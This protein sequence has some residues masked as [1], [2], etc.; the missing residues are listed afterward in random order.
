MSLKCI[1]QDPAPL[2]LQVDHRRGQGLC[3][4][5]I[6]HSY[7]AKGQPSLSSKDTGIVQTE[8]KRHSKFFLGIKKS[9]VYKASR[10]V[11]GNQKTLNS[12]AKNDEF[13]QKGGIDLLSL[14]LSKI[15][16]FKKIFLTSE[17]SRFKIIQPSS[18]DISLKTK[19]PKTKNKNNQ[20][21]ARAFQP[22]KYK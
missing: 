16:F 8:N 1:H 14:Q 15:K 2:T 12:L 13:W 20:T 5:R 10:S 22:L 6:G 7:S 11:L 21:S 3:Q 17:H 19:K 18:T 9:K 4:D